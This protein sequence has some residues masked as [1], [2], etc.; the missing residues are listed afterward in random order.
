[1]DF[2]VFGSVPI[3]QKKKKYTNFTIKEIGGPEEIIKWRKE[4]EAKA[5]LHQLRLN[6]RDDR[7]RSY[8]ELTGQKL[9]TPQLSGRSFADKMAEAIQRKEEYGKAELAVIANP[10]WV[11]PVPP[12]LTL[13][14]KIIRFFKQIWTHANF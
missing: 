11:P 4:Q 10:P 6:A 2:E 14:Q 7:I 9:E 12:Q 8:E 13:F 5:H 1:M 3:V